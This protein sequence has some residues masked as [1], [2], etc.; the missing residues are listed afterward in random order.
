MVGGICRPECRVLFPVLE[1]V[2][3]LRIGLKTYSGEEN[4][5]RTIRYWEKFSLSLGLSR[6]DL[7]VVYTKS[8]ALHR[9]SVYRKYLQDTATAPVT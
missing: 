6:F 1:K 4:N 3:I 2:V 5:T 9:N 7:G 8:F